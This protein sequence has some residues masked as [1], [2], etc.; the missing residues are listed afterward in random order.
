MQ[1]GMAPSCFG[2]LFN[3]DDTLGIVTVSTMKNTSVLSGRL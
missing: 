3:I 1:L 2:E